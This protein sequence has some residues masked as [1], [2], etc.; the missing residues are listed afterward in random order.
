MIPALLLVAFSTTVTLAIIRLGAMA[1][2]D[3]E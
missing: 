2:G 1:E 3:G